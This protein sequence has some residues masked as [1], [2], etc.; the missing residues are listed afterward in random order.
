MLGGAEGTLERYAK[1]TSDALDLPD[2]RAINVAGYALLE[3]RRFDEAIAV[4]QFNVTA[5]PKSWNAYDSLSEAF[6][7]AGLKQLALDNAKTSLKLNPD[8]SDSAR[9]IKRL[10][11]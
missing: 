7:T 9:R 2:E 11:D 6:E 3:R 10:Q 4:F 1:R 5:Y 8:N